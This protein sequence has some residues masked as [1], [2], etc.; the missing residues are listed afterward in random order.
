M[1]VEQFEKLRDLAEAMSEAVCEVADV[2]GVDSVNDEKG[3]AQAISSDHNR[4]AHLRR[5]FSAVR[6]LTDQANEMAFRE[7]T[8]FERSRLEVQ[9]HAKDKRRDNFLDW[10]DRLI[11]WLAGG[12]LAVFAYSTAIWVAERYSFFKVPIHHTVTEFAAEPSDGE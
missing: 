2:Y 12:V 3:L 9:L 10:R 7:M 1:D 6:A 5:M 8:L 11:R 4:S